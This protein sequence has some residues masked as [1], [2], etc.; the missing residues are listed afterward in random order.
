MIYVIRYVSH[1]ME[2]GA[3]G[4]AFNFQGSLREP[5]ERNPRAN[6]RPLSAASKLE[7]KRA[8]EQLATSKRL[9]TPK[10]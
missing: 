4:K 8:K 5:I 7:N 1:A 6:L 2:G 10:T 3:S 9:S